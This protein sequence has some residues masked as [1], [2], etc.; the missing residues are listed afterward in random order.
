M[1]VGTKIKTI[2]WSMLR[3]CCLGLLVAAVKAKDSKACT[4][5]EINIEGA[6]HHMFIKKADVLD[7]LNQNNIHAGETLNDINLRKTEESLEDNAWIKDAELFFDNRQVLHVNISE[8][9][10]VARIFT[11]DGSSF[12]I[13]SSGVRLPVNENATARVIVFTSFASDKK[14]LSNPDSLVLNDVKM[15][16][17][18][19][20]A[21]SFLSSL[22]QTVILMLIF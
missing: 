1:S 7:V 12:Y 8:S 14:V 2:S 10:P 22:M 4:N 16:A 20:T 5:I 21:D 3:L 18:Y 9:E 6:K 15:L 11:I 19:I 17:Q 13:D